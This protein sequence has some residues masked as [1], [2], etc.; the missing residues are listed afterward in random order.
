MDKREFLK[1]VNVGGKSY[2]IYDINK[3]GEKGI[4]HVDRL[5]FSIKILVENLLRKLDGRIVL[6]KDLLNIANWQK[7]YDAPVE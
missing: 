6:E 3:L 4:A 5:P 1:E 7:R 2:G